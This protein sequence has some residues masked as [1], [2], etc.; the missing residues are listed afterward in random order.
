MSMTD[1]HSA[2]PT[3][4][5]GGYAAPAEAGRETERDRVVAS[6]PE[7]DRTTGQ[8]HRM[9][10]EILQIEQSSGAWTRTRTTQLQRLVRCQLRYA[11]LSPR[12]VMEHC[13]ERGSTI[14]AATPWRYRPAARPAT[15]RRPASGPRRRTHPYSTPPILRSCD[16][17]LRRDGHPKAAVIVLADVLRTVFGLWRL[18]VGVQN[19]PAGASVIPSLPS[20]AAGR[21]AGDP[22]ACAG[23]RRRTGRTGAGSSVYNLLG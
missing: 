7:P 2:L 20:R 16:R 8:D 18:S 21:R 10:L 6:A 22:R 17:G 3:L 12:C 13:V 15:A 14:P 19:W 5:K 4:G 23:T 11:G 9:A 1:R